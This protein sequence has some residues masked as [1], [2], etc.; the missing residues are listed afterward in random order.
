MSIDT[1]PPSSTGFG[2]TRILSSKS[3]IIALSDSLEDNSNLKEIPAGSEEEDD[4]VDSPPRKKGATVRGKAD[5]AKSKS[6]QRYDLHRKFQTEWAAKLPW[7]GGI[8]ATD[9]LLHMVKCK[10][11]SDFD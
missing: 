2:G 5:S 9:G 4:E 10:V 7:A 1:G 6:Q 3:P 8:L 11:C